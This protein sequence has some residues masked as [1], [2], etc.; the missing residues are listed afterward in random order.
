MKVKMLLATLALTIT[1]ALALAGGGCGFG[2]A[3]TEDVVMSCAEGTI[4]DT[5]TQRCVPATG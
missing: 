1:P 3:K 4:F 5:E 2:H